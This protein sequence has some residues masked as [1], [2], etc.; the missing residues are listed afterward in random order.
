MKSAFQAGCK[1]LPVLT[2]PPPVPTLCE[3]AWSWVQSSAYGHQQS[4]NRLPGGFRTDEDPEDCH[5][6]NCCQREGQHGLRRLKVGRQHREE[7]ALQL[8]PCA[9][10]GPGGE[11]AG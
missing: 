7:E 4:L 10:A 5:I 8:R 6:A 11:A 3:T 2:L 1:M 9:G